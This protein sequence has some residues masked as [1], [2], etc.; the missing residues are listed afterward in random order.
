MCGPA[1]IHAG[2]TDE[3]YIS[4]A[5]GLHCV[6]RAHRAKQNE[7]KQND[8]R[9]KRNW[10]FT[11]EHIRQFNCA[12]SGRYR[13][14]RSLF[15]MC[16]RI[17]QH[18]L[19]H[20][21][22]PA[23]LFCLLVRAHLFST[24]RPAT[25][26]H[27]ERTARYG[28]LHNNNKYKVLKLLKCHLFC[29]YSSSILIFRK[30]VG[31]CSKFFSRVECLVKPPKSRCIN[32]PN[33]FFDRLRTRKE[34]CNCSIAIS[35]SGTGKSASMKFIMQINFT[36]GGRWRR[37]TVCFLSKSKRILEAAAGIMKCLV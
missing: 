6:A 19:Y 12:C 16:V 1:R 21:A 2:V 13:K 11:H 36:R 24:A 5:V 33:R 15:V 31:S 29:I 28:P 23:D 27:T 18:S 7:R 32:M 20:A 8:D 3:I 30:K 34:S 37:R 14:R 26:P 22:W 17:D 25:A 10:V 9:Q 4:L 35:K